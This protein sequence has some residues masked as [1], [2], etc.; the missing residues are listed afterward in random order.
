VPR[1]EILDSSEVFDAIVGVHL[2]NGHRKL[3]RTIEQVCARFHGIALKEVRW[4]VKHCYQCFP[5]HPH[6]RQQPG[7]APDAGALA[8]NHHR[9][10]YIT[11]TPSSSPTTKPDQDGSVGRFS[12][13]AAPQNVIVVTVV[14]VF[15]PEVAQG[16]DILV[17][18]EAKSGRVNLSALAYASLDFMALGIANWAAEVQNEESD[19]RRNRQAR[20]E[21]PNTMSHPCG[22]R[23]SW[24]LTGATFA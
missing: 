14:T 2:K 6:S 8:I 3:P 23:A 1:R 4:V 24:S 10:S 18:Y 12:G 9:A 16:Q 13:A 7:N 11:S 19:H 5:P 17:V 20:S 21:M 22:R 15:I